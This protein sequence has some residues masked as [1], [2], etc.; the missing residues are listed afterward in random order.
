MLTCSRPS[1]TLVARSLGKVYSDLRPILEDNRYLRGS[2]KGSRRCDAPWV[3]DDNSEVK[4]I[5]RS[6]ANVKGICVLVYV[7]AED[8][9]SNSVIDNLA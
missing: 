6:E 9:R 4:T 5:H 8:A 1:I 3:A 2:W 7:P